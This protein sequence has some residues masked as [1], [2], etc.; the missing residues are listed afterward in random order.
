MFTQSCARFMVDRLSSEEPPDHG[1]APWTRPAG[2]TETRLPRPGLAARIIERI[3]RRREVPA[4]T[5]DSALTRLG[6][7]SPHLLD[8]IGL[9]VA[10]VRE[11]GPVVIMEVNL[12]KAARGAP[13]PTGRGEAI[14]AE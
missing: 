11:A 5:L 14:A 7:T 3:A 8:D 2:G 1:L 6:S 12:P 4:E 10:R 13:A 9:R